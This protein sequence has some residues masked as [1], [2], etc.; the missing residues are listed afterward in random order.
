MPFRPW[1]HS[2]SPPTSCG[3]QGGY[4][5]HV[6][7]LGIRE[8]LWIAVDNPPTYR[9]DSTRASASG[10]STRKSPAAARRSVAGETT[11][12]GLVAPRRGRR[13]RSEPDEAQPQ[14]PRQRVGKQQPRITV[15]GRRYCVASAK[16]TSWVLSPISVSAT[17]RNEAQSSVIREKTRSILHPVIDRAAG[18]GRVD[19]VG[20]GC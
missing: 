4:P 12:V 16:A 6:G 7:R 19:R 10:P 3:G 15:H 18:P 5:Q 17:T 14:R 20:G 11:R 9:L 8:I 1:T 2:A 13:P